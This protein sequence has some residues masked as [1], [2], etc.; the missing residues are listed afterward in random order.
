[1]PITFPLTLLRRTNIIVRKDESVKMAFFKTFFQKLGLLLNLRDEEF[2]CDTCKLNYRD[3]CRRPERPNAR[4]CPDYR[5][6]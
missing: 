4:I 3:I 5:K 1:M 6:K 2:L